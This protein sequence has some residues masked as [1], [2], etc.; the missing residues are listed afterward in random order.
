[1]FLQDNS[2]K[3]LIHI[4]YLTVQ[5]LLFSMGI[6]PYIIIP[7]HILSKKVILHQ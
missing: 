5:L 7:A 3:S 6:V 4:A 1:M 2:V